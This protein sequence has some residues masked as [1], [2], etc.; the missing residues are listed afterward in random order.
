MI[1]D[2]GCTPKRFERTHSILG[3]VENTPKSPVYT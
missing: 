2:V 1:G 3:D